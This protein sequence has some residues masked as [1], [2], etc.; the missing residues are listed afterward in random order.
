MAKLIDYVEEVHTRHLEDYDKKLLKKTV[1][2]DLYDSL[3]DMARDNCNLIEDDAA[4]C[5]AEWNLFK[6]WYNEKGFTDD[7]WSYVLTAG[8]EEDQFGSEDYDY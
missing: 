2:F 3:Q 1:N 8:Y 5:D 7:D 6:A 4:F